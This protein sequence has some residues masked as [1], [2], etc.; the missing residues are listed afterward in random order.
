MLISIVDA[1]HPRRNPLFYKRE[2]PMDS[3]AR[4]QRSE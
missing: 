2:A 1:R 4:L 3:V